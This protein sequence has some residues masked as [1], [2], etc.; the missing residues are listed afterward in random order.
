MLRS[1]RSRADNGERPVLLSFCGGGDAK[2]ALCLLP[3]TEMVANFECPHCGAQYKVVSVEA[4][5]AHDQPLVCLSCGGPLRTREG[6]FALKY[7]RT[8]GSRSKRLNGYKPNY[9]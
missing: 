3:M 6:K 8:D 7:F 2:R 4:L 1:A 5:R 9:R